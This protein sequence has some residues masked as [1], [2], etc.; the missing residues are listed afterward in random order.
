MVVLIALDWNDQLNMVN[1]GRISAD[2]SRL[3]CSALTFRPKL[4][5]TVLSIFKTDGSEVLQ[6]SL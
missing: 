2:A 4:L 6:A 3:K 1:G 5:R